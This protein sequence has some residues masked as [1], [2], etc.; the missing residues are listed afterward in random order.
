V[1]LGG[2]AL[3]PCLPPPL[4]P[5]PLLFQPLG[6]LLH[7][8][9]PTLMSLLP[10]PLQSGSTV[11]GVEVATRNLTASPARDLPLPLL[12]PLPLPVAVALLSFCLRAATATQRRTCGVSLLTTTAQV[13]LRLWLLGFGNS[14]G[15]GDEGGG[16]VTRFMEHLLTARGL[17][18]LIEAMCMRSARRGCCCRS[19]CWAWWTLVRRIQILP[20]CLSCL[21]PLLCMPV[22]PQESGKRGCLQ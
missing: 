4:P 17:W 22:V 19:S 21:L 2:E 20:P 5:A 7:L 18:L 13:V 1:V 15:G 9:R 16:E 6:L 11:V 14:E 3:P 12:L 8:R 10:W